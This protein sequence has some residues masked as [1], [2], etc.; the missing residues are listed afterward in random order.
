MLCSQPK[1]QDGNLDTLTDQREFSEKQHQNHECGQIQMWLHRCDFSLRW[2]IHM[3]WWAE[4]TRSSSVCRK[5]LSQLVWKARLQT[6]RELRFRENMGAIWAEEGVGVQGNSQYLHFQ[7]STQQRETPLRR[8]WLELE[9]KLLCFPGYS[10]PGAQVSMSGHLIYRKSQWNWQQSCRAGL[11]P[12]LERV[13]SRLG[14]RQMNLESS[15]LMGRSLS[16]KLLAI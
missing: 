14:R 5:L 15:G 7:V 12:V 13:V 9:E 2:N 11:K 8:Q 4:P 3:R 1:H 16:S 10:M 6:G